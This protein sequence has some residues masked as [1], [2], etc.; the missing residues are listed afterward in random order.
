MPSIK[1][2]AKKLFND[3][4]LDYN[5]RGETLSIEEF[6]EIS[7]YIIKKQNLK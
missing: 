2:V 4:K 5:T 3:L 7:N 1:D 6:A